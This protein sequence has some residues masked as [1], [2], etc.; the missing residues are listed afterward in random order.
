[1]F[2]S[3]D[4]AYP[5]WIFIIFQLKVINYDCSGH[6]FVTFLKYFGSIFKTELSVICSLWNNIFV[7]KKIH[8]IYVL[9]IWLVKS[10][11]HNINEEALV[12]IYCSFDMSIY[13]R[14]YW[15]RRLRRRLRHWSI[16]LSYQISMTVSC[17]K[18]INYSLSFECELT[19]LFFLCKQF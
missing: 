1:M 11:V 7:R 6:K 8:R 13:Y 3:D 17:W 15:C 2:Q 14:M 18:I 19:L 9:N 12:Y 16:A 4:N 5:V 10:F